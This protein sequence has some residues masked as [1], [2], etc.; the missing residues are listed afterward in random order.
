MSMI[1]VDGVPISFQV[2][3]TGVPILF[4][5]PPVVASVVFQYQVQA[6]ARDFRVILMV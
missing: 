4:I 1:H 6:L 5:P 3:G 2:I